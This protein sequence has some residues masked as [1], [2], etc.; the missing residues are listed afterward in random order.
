ML[1]IIKRQTSQTT[2]R[3]LHSSPHLNKIKIVKEDESKPGVLD[4][5]NEKDFKQTDEGKVAKFYESAFWFKKQKEKSKSKFYD[6]NMDIKI[7]L[8]L[9]FGGGCYYLYVDRKWKLHFNNNYHNKAINEIKKD[10]RLKVA[11]GGDLVFKEF[12][13]AGESCLTKDVARVMFY[14]TGPNKKEGVVMCEAVYDEEN[15]EWVLSRVY[16][17]FWADPKNKDL[18]P[19]H[20]QIFPKKM[21]NPVGWQS[22]RE[23]YVRSQYITTPDKYMMGDKRNNDNKKSEIEENNSKL[24]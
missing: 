11:F 9:L 23:Q 3:L 8:A 5:L 6:G 19:V 17:D 4:A 16:L 2:N 15:F 24:E 13:K 14:V 1:R 18:P 22:A 7:M 10:I 21:I 20:M 12:L